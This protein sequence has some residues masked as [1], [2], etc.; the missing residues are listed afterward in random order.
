ME[1]KRGPGQPPKPG[2][3]EK[4][5]LTEQH[6]ANI[7]AA[8]SAYGWRNL[9]DA[10][11]GL[12]DLLA[13]HTITTGG[14][15]RTITATHEI[16]FE[17]E[18]QRENGAGGWMIPAHLVPVGTEVNADY[19]LIE[20]D[21]WGSLAI[22]EDDTAWDEIAD[23]ELA[24]WGFRRAGATRSEGSVAVVPVALSPRIIEVDDQT[25]MREFYP[26][27]D[28]EALDDDQADKLEKLTRET[29]RPLVEKE[30]A[31]MYGVEVTGWSDIH[32]DMQIKGLDLL[33]GEATVFQSIIRSQQEQVWRAAWDA[34]DEAAIWAQ[35]E[36]A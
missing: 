31:D 22:T 29:L 1:I 30:W 26:L 9:S 3:Q 15:M 34:L 33:G 12:A 6:K 10:T 4:V 7:L 14:T 19:D 28:V 35:I 36:E 17:I 11:A 23:E 18:N 25:S 20:R 32:E 2:K 27:R 5:R 13:V 16:H 24:D 8:G 21:R